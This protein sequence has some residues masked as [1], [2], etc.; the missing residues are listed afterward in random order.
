MTYFITNRFRS[1]NKITVQREA[2]AVQSVTVSGGK[3]AG[4]YIEVWLLL[5]CMDPPT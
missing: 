2:E 1:A 5:Q 3:N 4:R